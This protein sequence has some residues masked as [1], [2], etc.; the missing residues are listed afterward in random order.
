[1]SARVPFAVVPFGPDDLSPAAALERLCFAEPW[2]EHALE[3]FLGSDAV[4]FT[5]RVGT[6]TVG[7]GGMMLAPDEGQITNIAVHPAYRRRGIG[8]ALLLALLDEAARRK[9]GAVVLEVRVSN[10]AAIALYESLG[11]V[12]AGLRKGFY[13]KPV[14]DALVMVR[15]SSVN[16]EETP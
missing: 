7:Y 12:C 6:E 16:A 10:A 8:R 2:S 9:R 13:R 11:F 15:R 1:M 5:A 3:L 14:E 4:A